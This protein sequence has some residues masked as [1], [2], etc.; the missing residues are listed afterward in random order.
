MTNSSPRTASLSGW[1]TDPSALGGRIR[2][3]I[4]QACAV[5]AVERGL[6]GLWPAL[7]FAGA[8]LALALFGLLALIPWPLQA[9]LLAATITASGLALASGLAGF[10]FPAWHEG[11]RRLERDSG[12]S[13]RPISESHD[14]LIGNDPFSVSLWRLHQTR[15]IP[16]ADLKAAW[17]HLDLSR[18]DPKHLRYLLLLILAVALVMARGEWQPRL[19]RAFDSG[20]GLNL[21]ID[22]WV[23][24]PA[25]TGLP[26]VYLAHGEAAAI[27]VP[28]GSQLNVRV[29]GGDHA[30]GLSLGAGQ[31]PRFKGAQSEYAAV[32]RIGQDAHVRVRASG[33]VIGNWNLRVIA[34]A[35]PRV[36]FTAKPSATEHQATQFAF[37]ASDDYGVTG[38][39]VVIRPHGSK[40]K[41][42]VVDLPLAEAS[43]KSLDQTIYSDL[44]AHP[45]AGLMVDATLEA[46]DGAGQ[47]GRSAPMTFRLPALVFT[48]PLARA[49][50]EQRQILAAG[51]AAARRRVAVAL[52]AFAVAPD[53]F[54]AGKDGIYLALRAAYWGLRSARSDSDME[55]VE[56]LLWQTAVAIDHGALLAAAEELRRLKA[57]LDAALAAHA[58]QDVIDALLQ[59]YNQAMQRYMQALANDPNARQSQQM[60]AGGDTKTITEDDIQKLMQTIQ[61]LSASGNREMAAQLLAMLQNMLEN[62]HM[63]QNPSG[64]GGG[65]PADKARDQAIQ[66]L[67]DMMGQQRALLDK[68]LRQR[69]GSGDPK[70]GGPQGLARQQ[71]ALQKQLGDALK[72]MDPKLKDALGEAERAMGKAGQALG[73]KD[74]DNAGNE[75]KNALDAL[76]KG[77]DTL[78]QEEKGKGQ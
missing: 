25:Y 76:R 11:A 61:Q 12:L 38:A 15:T 10:R 45:Y 66:K 65:S 18:R 7:G 57:L 30:P 68:T 35:P 64:K 48:D 75:Q 51:D 37:H 5:I 9:L 3:L 41:P 42:L 73:Q 78:A 16:V 72:G 33:H 54:Y 23:D 20:A 50:I 40:A 55:H 62:M 8:Y 44:T 21:G 1:R 22:A 63:A 24:P 67:G 2:R 43:A 4:G 53:K 29:H 36:R 27:A 13:H 74:F 59:K 26:P 49:L 28:V 46:R 58:P 69:Q 34:D 77:A 31:R 70:D 47:I 71:G 56:A 39:K 60:Q 19:L 17:P 52:D 14:R 6:P 32:A